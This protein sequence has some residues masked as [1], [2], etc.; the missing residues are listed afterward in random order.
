MSPFGFGGTRDVRGAP[1]TADWAGTGG[2]TANPDFVQRLAAKDRSADAPTSPRNILRDFYVKDLKLPA[3][4]EDIYVDA[5]VAM[6]TGPMNYPGDVVPVASWPAIGPGDGGV[7]NAI[8]GKHCNLSGFAHIDP[9]PPVLW[10]RGADDAIVSDNSMF[11]L[12]A[13]GKMGAVPG[14]PGD[15]AYPAQPMIGQI[16]A[17][18]DAYAAG[19]GV[20]K[21]EVLVYCG[22]SPHLE[23]PERFL[24]LLLAQVG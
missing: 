1:C 18:L 14:W 3:E 23:H 24:E 22:H 6:S 15:E 2:G 12:G 21:E 5:M 10:I 4:L 13:L 16:R 8:S 19:G 11:D 7:N 17:V 20:V 9:K